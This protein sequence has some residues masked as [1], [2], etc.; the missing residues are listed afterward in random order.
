MSRL[1]GY[2]KWLMSGYDDQPDYNQQEEKAHSDAL[3]SMQTGG[4][5]DPFED[6]NW[7]EAISQLELPEEIEDITKATEEQKK[8]V[9]EYWYKIAYDYFLG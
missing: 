4:Q 6:S 8:K 9:K 1:N 2:D 5:H 3:E 7:F